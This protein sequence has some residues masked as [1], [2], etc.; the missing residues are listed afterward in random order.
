M[1]S[2]GQLAF[3]PD[4]RVLAA[5]EGGLGVRLWHPAT[6]REVDFLKAPDDGNNQWVG[7]SLEGNWFGLRLGNGEVRLFPVAALS[8]R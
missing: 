7:F 8:G 1:T 4:G 6:A 5:Q 3:S 2:V